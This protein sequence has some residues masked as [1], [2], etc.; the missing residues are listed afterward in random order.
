MNQ[1]SMTT[2]MLALIG[3]MVCADSASAQVPVRT[4]TLTVSVDSTKPNGAAWDAF[5]GAPDIAV[6]SGSSAGTQCNMV[7]G[8]QARCQDSFACRYSMTLPTTFS[9][10]VWDLD[11]S[12]DDIIGTCYIDHPGSYRCGSATLTVRCSLADREDKQGSVCTC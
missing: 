4:W 8:S 3:G 6:C 10:T 9:I 1:L 7:A 5:G 2:A 11:V 12:A